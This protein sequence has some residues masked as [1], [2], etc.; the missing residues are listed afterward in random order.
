MVK[1][2]LLEVLNFS[3]DCFSIN[4]PAPLPASVDSFSEYLVKDYDKTCVDKKS[5]CVTSFFQVN[6]FLLLSP[7]LFMCIDIELYS[8]SSL[9]L[10][11]SVF[12]PLTC[13]H[14][15][16]SDIFSTEFCKS[17]ADSDIYTPLTGLSLLCA[18]N[19]GEILM[20]GIGV[21]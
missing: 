7:S 4:R 9:F 17:K 1:L 2:C 18:A 21:I 12:S 11:L 6:L 20:L 13:F 15:L 8:F 5:C 14:P 3:F 10:L 19:D 16:Q